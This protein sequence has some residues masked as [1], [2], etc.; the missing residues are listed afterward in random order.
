MVSVGPVTIH[1]AIESS[2]A[3]SLFRTGRARVA[4]DDTEHSKAI[5]RTSLRLLPAEIARSSLAAGK[6]IGRTET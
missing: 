2:N 3:L 6:I 5:I 4:E 1:A